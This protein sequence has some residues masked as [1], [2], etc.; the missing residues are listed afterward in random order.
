VHDLR[1][2]REEALLACD[3]FND[4]H[5]RNLDGFLAHMLAAW[6]HALRAIAAKGGRIEQLD[7]AELASRLRRY[8]PSA[9]SPV[10]ANLEFFIELH[11]RIAH[12]F[13][14]KR[15]RFVETLVSG[16]INALLLNF[17]RT[18]VAEFGARA[19]LADALRFPV[20]LSS[21]TTES[22]LLLEQAYEGMPSSLTRFIDSYE[23]RLDPSVRVSEA[24]DFRIYLMPKASPAARDLP[25]EFVDLSKLSAEEAEAVENARVIIRDRQIEAINVNRLKASEVV[26][27]VQ[28][29]F[30]SFS[31]YLHTLAWRHYG[32][33]PPSNTPDPACTDTRFALY[34]RAH[35]DYLYT[36][37]WVERLKEELAADP[38]AAI[39]SW[40]PARAERSVPDSP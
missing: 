23:A 16:K 22:A 8:F 4:R 12:R 35:R 30:P 7:G 27:R 31:L 29:I 2:A 28:T 37:A 20:F 24:Y 39:G 40:K 14:R 9:A 33:R 11:E 5:E 18:L 13:S 10:R 17:E 26:A 1:A 36:E 32:V 25:V 34:D 38:E 3:L 15:L 21:L 19:S 6:R